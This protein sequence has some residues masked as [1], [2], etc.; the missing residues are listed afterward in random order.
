MPYGV[1]ANVKAPHRFL[2]MGSLCWILLTNPGWGGERVMVRGISRGGRR[3]STY[4]DARDLQNFR[5][6]WFP[7]AVQYHGAIPFES[8]EEAAQWAS[9]MNERF[10]EQAVRD[11]AAGYGRQP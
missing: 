5:P 1:K 10:G 11:H 2:R 4:V 6:G 7:D 3:V 8:R 9:T